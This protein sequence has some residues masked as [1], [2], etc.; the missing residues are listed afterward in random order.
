LKEKE[1]QGMQ[2]SAITPD[3]AV[4]M[5]EEGNARYLANKQEHPHLGQDRRASTSSEGQRPF[6]TVLSCSD[7]RVPVELLFDRG[8]GD[9]FVVRVAGNVVGP[10]ELGS[11]EYAVDHL[12]TPVIVVLGHAQCGAVNAVVKEGLLPG[13]LRGLS[14]KILPAVEHTRKQHPGMGDA[15]LV[16]ESVKTNVWKSIEDAFRASESIRE[17]TK[18]GQLKVIG[19]FYHLDAGN[20]EWMGMHPEQAQL[21]AA[22]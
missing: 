14:E 3:A 18:A 11:V 2:P 1:V 7:S 22:L 10:S 13:N 21:L 17:K 20:V 5:L 8:I 4:K 12:G 19:A 16:H 6:A 15:Q 9:V